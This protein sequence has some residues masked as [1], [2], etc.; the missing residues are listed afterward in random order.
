MNPYEVACKGLADSI[1]GALLCGVIEI[2]SNRLLALYS[3]EGKAADFQAAFITSCQELLRGPNKQVF[4]QGSD[5]SI[6]AEAQVASAHTCHIAKTLAD[7]RRAIVLVV[8]KDTNVGLGWAEVKVTAA[9]LDR[10]EAA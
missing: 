1:D 2:A 3:T 7:G 6:Y 8:R 10:V 4:G 9:A 5:G